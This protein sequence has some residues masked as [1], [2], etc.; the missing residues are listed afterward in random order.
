ML[1]PPETTVHVH[2][3]RLQ[4]YARTNALTWCGQAWVATFIDPKGDKTPR[5]RRCERA[6]LRH[7]LNLTVQS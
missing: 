4:H 3:G 5:C 6:L 7:A 2:R 1:E